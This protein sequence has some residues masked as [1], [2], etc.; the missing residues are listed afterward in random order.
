VKILLEIDDK[1]NYMYSSIEYD[2]RCVL[3]RPGE[4]Y[5]AVT[6]PKHGDE[7]S[8]IDFS[9]RCDYGSYALSKCGA[10]FLAV[11]EGSSRSSAHNISEIGEKS[12]GIFS[13][14]EVRPENRSRR[15]VPGSC[16][17]VVIMCVQSSFK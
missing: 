17:S 10:D 9:T 14:I 13:P 12:G 2:R 5:L 6:L 7:I 16:A 4:T 8:D 3:S 11:K 1:T 15:A